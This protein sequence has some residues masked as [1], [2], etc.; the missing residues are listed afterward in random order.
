MVTYHNFGARTTASANKLALPG[1]STLQ[2]D[3]RQMC[4]VGCW[5]KVGELFGIWARNI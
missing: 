5:S 1:F 2:S 4:S 3:S